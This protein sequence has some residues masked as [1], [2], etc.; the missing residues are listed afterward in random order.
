MEVGEYPLDESYGESVWCGLVVE[1]REGVHSPVCDEYDGVLL[2]VAY[3]EW[4][5]MVRLYLGE[6]DVGTVLG[7]DSPCRCRRGGDGEQQ[8]YCCKG[9]YV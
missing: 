3:A 1:E 5:H 2:G 6:G 8:E 9:Q 7:H 4:L